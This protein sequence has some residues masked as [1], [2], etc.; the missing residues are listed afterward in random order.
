MK[1]AF[2]ILISVLLLQPLLDSFDVADHNA[3]FNHTSVLL[4]EEMTLKPIALPM[5][6]TSY[7]NQSMPSLANS[8]LTQPKKAIVMFV[9]AL[10]LSI[11]CNCLNLLVSISLKLNHLISTSN[12]LT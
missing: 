3:A 6:I 5:A 7:I 1:A 10:R 12:R 4:S 11:R 8:C 2:F 9:T